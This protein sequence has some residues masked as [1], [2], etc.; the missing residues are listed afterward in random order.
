VSWTFTILGPPATKGSTRS[1]DEGDISRAADYLRGLIRDHDSMRFVS[2]VQEGVPVSKA[3][4]R[5]SRKSGRFY[6]PSTTSTAE[7]EMAWRFKRA[8]GAESF[9]GNVALVAVF[10]RPNRQRIDAD[11]LMKLVLD[12]GTKAGVWGDDCQ[13][14]HQASVI[15]L[16]AGR[17]RT[18]VALCDV[19]STMQRARM[20]S[21]VCKQ[22]AK[23]F[24]RD[25]AR[26]G[27]RTPIF[28]SP[29]C[30][31]ASTPIEQAKCPKCETVFQRKRSG[32]RYCSNTCK[33]ADILVRQHAANQ[34]P[35]SLCQQCGARVSRREYLFCANCRRKGRK[36]GS[37]NKAKTTVTVQ[38][39]C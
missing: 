23:P 33:N 1:A 24:E 17:P 30:R 29:T 15:E 26:V 4:A 37:K 35:P 11:N 19:E 25:R 16:D 6:T 32:Q 13:V 20:A 22:C 27:R 8:V 2:F 18:V 14:T 5:W 9:T 12:A 28:C 10:Y 3:R 7:Q 36:P 31:K 38:R 34:R 39:V 21:F